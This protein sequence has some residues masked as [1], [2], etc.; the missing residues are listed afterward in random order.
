CQR[1]REAR[2]HLRCLADV[3]GEL[4]ESGPLVTA[5]VRWDPAIRGPRCGPPAGPPRRTKAVGDHRPRRVAPPRGPFSLVATS[6]SAL[7]RPPTPGRLRLGP[8]RAALPRRHRA[9]A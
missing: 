5:V 9:T 3:A 1:S 7:R 6:P 2:G 8:A 4:A